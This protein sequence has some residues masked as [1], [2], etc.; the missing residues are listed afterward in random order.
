ML[1]K[2]TIPYFSFDYANGVIGAEVNAAFADVF[3]SKWYILGRYLNEFEKSYAVYNDTA[4]CTGVG[5]GLDALHICLKAVNAGPGDEI[6]VPSNT[7]IATWLAVSYTGATIVPVEPRP[8]T[9]NI[10]PE[11]IAAAITPRTKAIIPVHLYGQSC[12]MDEIMAI[13]QAHGLYVI[14]DN[15]QAHS[16]RYNGKKTGSFGIANATSFYPT[17]NLGAL[18]DG[19][20][21]TTNDPEIDRITKLLRNYGSSIKYQ[22]EIIGFNSRLDEMQASFLSVKLK[23]IDAFTRERKKIAGAY[24]TKLAGIPGLVT[25][26]VAPLS[27]HVYHVYAVKTEKRDE[28]QR[29][30]ESKGI[31]LMIHY[32][33]P[34]HL[35]PAYQHLGFKKGDFIIAEDLAATCLSLPLYPGLKDDEIDYIVSCI[36]AFYG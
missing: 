22:H 17:K 24:N 23:Y 18:G 16:A 9:Y 35:Q 33:R 6:I 12:E 8:N 31:G 5:N 7:Y 13:S 32:P 10:D 11:N 19:G 3:K 36:R 4:F 34:P 28:L 2:K 20:A 29:Y 14:E 26:Q 27:E 1:T 21:I 25:P 15:A 30:L